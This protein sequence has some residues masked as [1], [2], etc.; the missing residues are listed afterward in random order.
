MSTND[1]NKAQQIRADLNNLADVIET[2]V[3][4][5]TP[6]KVEIPDRS[7]SG[8]AIRGGQIAQFSSTG[9]RDDSTRLVVLVNDDGILTDFIDVETLVGNVK[10]EQNLYVGGE[11]RAASLHVNE[12]TSDIRHERSSPL[13]FHLENEDSAYGQGLHW[14]GNAPTKQF[15]LRNGPDRLFST[16]TLDLAKDKEYMIDRVAV[17]GRHELGPTVTKSNLRSVGTLDN[18]DVAGD[19][20]VDEFL[21]YNSVSQRLSLGLEEPNGMFSLASFDGEF[22]IDPEGARTRLGNYTNSDLALITDDTDR[23]VV[24]KN[25]HIFLGPKGSNHTTVTVNGKLGVGVTNVSS[26]VDLEV[27]GALR[28]ENKKF[29]VGPGSPTNGSYKIGDIVWN[30]SPKPTGFIGWVCV[31]DGSPGTW[32]PF[33]KIGE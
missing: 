5:T 20:N 29:E 24:T 14:R 32:K 27:T 4:K 33:G 2:I 8:N 28:F 31:K 12:I 16:E 15:V 25:G 13:E 6:L 10:I 7:L 30:E 1:I 23:I 9:I 26:D 21:F 22:I 19:L 3:Y 18:L 11:I 17:L